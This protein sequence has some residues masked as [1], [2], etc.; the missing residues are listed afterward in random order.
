MFSLSF[1]PETNLSPE[2]RTELENIRFS[3]QKI[4]FLTEEA[5]NALALNEIFSYE[6]ARK[7]K[8][9]ARFSEVL[10]EVE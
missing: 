8:T 1:A 2:R 5:R 10:T 3:F 7:F 6:D 4:T 9:F